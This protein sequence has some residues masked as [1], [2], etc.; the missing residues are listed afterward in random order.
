M[1]IIITKVIIMFMVT[2]NINL[3][4]YDNNQSDNNVYGD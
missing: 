4:D 1:I 3:N 2:N